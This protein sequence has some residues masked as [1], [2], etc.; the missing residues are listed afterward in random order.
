MTSNSENT[1]GNVEKKNKSNSS[2]LIIDDAEGSRNV[3][4]S[5]IAIYGHNVFTA[6]NIT[7]TRQVL[8][9]Q[10]IDV[11]FLEYDID[12]G[13]GLEFLKT[14]KSSREYVN[15]PVIIISGDNDIERSVQCI[16][17]GAEDYLVKP[18]NP[19]ILKA[20]LENSIAKKKAH[21]NEIDYIAKIKE[22]QRQAIEKEKMSSLGNMALAISQELQNPLNLVTNLS[23]ICNDL[24][25]EA[26]QKLSN[27]P[28]NCKGIVNDI[29]QILD[30]LTADLTKIK[31]HSHKADKIL[32][33]IIDQSTNS[34][35]AFYPAD[36]NKVITE[37]VKMIIADYKNAN[38]P[39]NAKIKLSLDNKIPE[40]LTLCVQ[41]ISQAIY[42]LLDN[43]IRSLHLKG[44]AN[45]SPTIEIKTK[46]FDEH[47]EI[48]IY[49]NGIGIEKGLTRVIFEP[50]FT[51]STSGRPGLGLSAVSE[52]IVQL[53]RGSIKVK[54]EKDKFAEFIVT[55]PKERANSLH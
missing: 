12:G 48:S 25:N 11:I 1:I 8:K 14:L 19:T 17:K 31:E 27:T 5:R 43:A 45:E 29:N 35:A 40:D 55:L 36:L 53:H 30:S 37:T 4:K 18:L 46:N 23:D 15:I 7:E 44:A 50:F 2:V 26:K 24:C 20:R 38:R 21:D 9:S 52:S 16:S 41:S 33:F 39:I 32:R 6:D 54:T 34:K 49:D 10:K 13:N 42:N 28:S 3:I 22:E 47:V 51:T